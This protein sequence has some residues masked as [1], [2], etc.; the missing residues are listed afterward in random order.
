M[1]LIP[2][3]Y[4]ITLLLIS[5]QQ[6]PT[7]QK[8][9][10][11]RAIYHW[12]TVFEPSSEEKALLDS[13]HINKIY[14]KF[15][16]IAWD[17]STKNQ[18]LPIAKFYSKDSSYLTKSNVVVVP[19]VF[20]TNESLVHSELTYMP[21]LASNI[22]SLVKQMVNINKLQNITEVQIDCDWTRT[23][24]EKYFALLT[25][26]QLADTTIVI[27]STI[28]LHQIKY[29]SKAG[30]PPIK[31]G[32]LMCYNMANLTNLSTANSILDVATLQ[33]YLSFLQQYP[34]P[35][36]VA[37]PLFEW[38]VLFNKGRYKGIIHTFN[39]TQLNTTIAQQQLNTYT[40]I[41]DTIIDNISFRKGDVIRHEYPSQLALMNASKIISNRLH[42]TNCTIALYHLDSLTL[43]K[44]K[45]NELENIYTSFY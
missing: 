8:R 11:E 39:Y 10:V 21:T 9:K 40:L 1:K 16:D 33:S 29:A 6:A 42:K 24:S 5:C 3:I 17:K 31:K 13:I 7:N 4:F 25:A 32:M 38:G 41:H 45:P 43:K 35:L 2:P 22:Y 18:V 34:I 36:D 27:S 19:T 28:R 37:L 15:F 30:V 12:K 14:L 44:F 23:T 26:I 20:I